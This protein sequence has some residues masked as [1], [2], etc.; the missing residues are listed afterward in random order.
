MALRKNRRGL[1]RGL[2]TLLAAGPTPGVRELDLAQIEPN[3]TQPRQ[4]F[5]RKSL[6]EL[7]ESIKLHGLVQPLVVSAVGDERY[8]LIVGE[9]R[10]RASRIAGL[11]RVPAVIRDVSDRNALELALIENVQRADLNP[12]EEATAY[13]RLMEDFGLSQQE[14]G[15][16][17]G[18]SRVAIA[19]RLRL[20]ALPPTVQRS[21]IERRISEGHA[22][23][24]LA[25]PTDQQRLAALE[26]VER[27]GLSVRQTE[28]LVRKILETREPQTLPPVDPDRNRLEEDLSRSLGTR[29]ALQQRNRGGRIV[30]EYYS[31]DEFQTLYDRLVQ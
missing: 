1:G 30:I 5:E 15:E 23:A 9:R 26:R 22:R 14:V 25:L 27:D 20:L 12:L 16:R 21:L 2:D 6:D 29:V 11:T 19:N 13:Q 4:H 28:G 3:P 24:L 18:L 7:A 17:V 8:R 31:D 10:W